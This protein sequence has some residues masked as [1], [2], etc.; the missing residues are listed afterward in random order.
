MAIVYNA[1]GVAGKVCNRCGE[2]K[3]VSEF[4]RYSRSLDG[5][6]ADCKACRNAENRAYDDLRRKQKPVNVRPKPKPAITGKVCIGCKEWK[7]VSE[8]SPLRWKGKPLGNGYRSHCKACSN[9]QQRAK[10]AAY[11][12]PYRDKARKY[13]ASRRDQSNNYQRAWRN[14]NREKVRASLHAYREANREQIRNT[15][16][17]RRDAN[18]EHYRAIG[19][20]AYAN[21]REKRRIYNRA[22]RKAHPER[23]REQVRTRRNRK[24]QAEG[25]HSE[26]EWEALKA[27]YNYTCLKCGRCEPEITLTRDHV[28]PITQGGSDWITNIQPLCHTCN[29]SK[30]NKSIDYRINWHLTGKISSETSAGQQ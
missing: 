25:S 23:Y 8:F 3:Q 6:K 26:A 15:A 20:K 27:K 13:M 12:E 1:D 2:W 4:H 16:K 17:K 28:I 11:P 21:N 5:H 22:Y 7:P 19:R 10:R 18:L 30:N 29:S 9:A 14:E 24:Y